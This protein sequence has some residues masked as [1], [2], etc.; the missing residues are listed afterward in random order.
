VRQL[1]KD[2]EAGVNLSASEQLQA[3]GAESLD[4]E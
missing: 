3:L 2:L 4:R 1:A